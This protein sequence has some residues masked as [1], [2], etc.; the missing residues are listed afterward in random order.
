MATLIDSLSNLIAPATGQIATKL[1]ES[2]AAIS[3]GVTSTLGSV[4]GGLLNKTKDTAAF[5]HIF[6]V[7]SSAPPST[8]LTGDLESAVGA[9]GTS[10]GGAASTATNFLGML[11][12]GGTNAITDLIGR[13]ASFKNAGSAAALLKFAVPMVINFFGTKIREGGLNAGSLSNL[14]TGE[15]DSIVAAAPP[16]LM[17]VLESAPQTPRVEEREV[18][19]TAV[20]A[21]R[22]YVGT[23]RNERSG[24]WLW[25]AVGVAAAVLAWIAISQSRPHRVAQRVSAGVVAIDTTARPGGIIDTAGGEVSPNISGLGALGKRR[26]PNGIVISVPAYGMESRVLGF[27]EGSQ[28]VGAL[29]TFDFDRLTFDQGSV[30][31]RPE[32]QDQVTSIA[33]IMR[34]YPDLTVKI[35]GYSDNAASPVAN[36]KQSQQRANAV[37]QALVG[38]GIASKRI[39]TEAGGVR[40]RSV[41]FE[42]THK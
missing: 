13:T 28:P 2:E 26:L 24:R 12:G 3:G 11:F 1:G 30:H 42:I 8:N 29:S 38:S 15:R 36:L 27:M 16:G 6:D 5:G 9:M 40:N 20:P 7:M 21:D 17:N 33:S 39:T 37:K 22:P 4:L 10:G 19:R 18:Q 14:L 25:P 34:A 23:T 32:S 41:T 35:A 31:L